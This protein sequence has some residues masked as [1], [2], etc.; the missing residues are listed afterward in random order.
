MTAKQAYEMLNEQNPFGVRKLFAQRIDSELLEDY[1]FVIGQY[2]V[3]IANQDSPDIWTII[4]VDNKSI[5]YD[6]EG[7]PRSN[8]GSICLIGDN[9]D[10]FRSSFGN[11]HMDTRGIWVWDID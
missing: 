4:V 7:R 3:P 2:Q 10:S 8:G 1:T 11:S 9:G 6:S 5:E